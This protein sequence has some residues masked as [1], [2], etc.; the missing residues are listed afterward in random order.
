ME[1]FFVSLPI[2]FIVFAGWILR[3]LQVVKDE[4]LHALN[5]FAY[6][7]SLPALII[8]SFWSIDFSKKETIETLGA[9]LFTVLAFCAVVFFILSAIKIETQK[10]AAIFIAATVGNTVYMG[11]PLVELG[12]GKAFLTQGALIAVIYLVVPLLVSIFVIRYWHDKRHQVLKHVVELAKNPLTISMLVGVI[13]SFMSLKG[14]WWSSLTRAIQM[15][16]ST[17]S[18]VAL[19][20]LG[21]F[22]YGR[23]L[24]KDIFSVALA[25][26]IKMILF[27]LIVF[28]GM[29]YAFKTSDIRV[30]ALL[31]STPVAV[32]TF[33]IAERYKLDE[34]L[35]ANAIIFST[36]LS[37]IVAP[38]ILLI[39]S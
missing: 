7:V 29:F 32:T 35:I 2:F 17:A 13:M 21:A 33:V 1:I 4:W 38:I 25:S 18:P 8:S 34:S 16:G 27:P 9:S 30:F 5:Q 6:Y 31:A 15:L 37:F 12:C 26:G 3:R 11:F 24:K 28:G 23:F 14:Q 19:F 20:A 39:F 36:L 10:K 22:L